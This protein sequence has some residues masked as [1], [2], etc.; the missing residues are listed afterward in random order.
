MRNRIN[1]IR[2]EKGMSN[3][4]LAEKA[5][6]N[7]VTI[8]KAEKQ[9]IETTRMSLNTFL[10]IA[11]ALDVTIFELLDCDSDLNKRF[12]KI[13]SIRMKSF[14]KAKVTGLKKAIAQLDKVKEELTNALG[15]DHDEE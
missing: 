15:R 14:S 12:E 5:N 7:R 10:R 3:Y 2:Q 1:E 9:D 13:K 6:I 11:D 8:I 4:E